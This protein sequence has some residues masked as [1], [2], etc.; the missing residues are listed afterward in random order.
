RR[1]FTDV[2]IEVA[3]TVAGQASLAVE[4]ARL[5]DETLGLTI[6]NQAVVESIQQGI[7]VLD[8]DLTIRRVNRYMM[9]RY[10]WSTSAVGHLLFDHRPDYAAFLREPI[11]VVLALGE[12]QVRYEVERRD[13]SGAPSI[14]NYYLYPMREGSAVT[15]IVLLLEDVTERARLEADLN[16][17][18]VQMAALSEVSSRITSTLEPD[19]VIDVVLDALNRVVPYDGVSLWLRSTAR[20][21]LYIAAARG[22]ETPDATAVSE[23]VGLTVE[24]AYSPLFREMADKARV[25]NARDV[26]E[27]PR[28]PYGSEAIY[29]NWLGAP[30]ISKGEIMGVMALEKREPNYYGALHE[31]LALTFAN[32]AAVALDNARLFQETR[33]RASALDQQAQRLALLNRVSLALA[34]TLDLENIFEIALRE[35]AIALEAVEGSAMQVD[36]ENRLCTVIVEYPRGD[37]PPDASYNLGRYEALERVVENLI[38]LVVDYTEDNPVAASMH[39][40]LRRRDVRQSLLVPMVVGGDVIGLLRLDSTGPG[41]SFT[42]DQVELAQTITSQAATAVQNAGLF[43][44]GQIRT[45]ELETLFESAQATAVTLDLNEVMRR[46]TIQMLAAVGADACAVFLWDDVN[47]LLDVRGEISAR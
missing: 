11:A 10:N 14:R 42:P 16:T 26:A 15:G 3:E 9:E 31:Q 1:A 28:F 22:Y 21:E 17:R 41:R 18:A 34:Q 44:Q 5:Y 20:E 46:V 8:R 7:V 45:R 43:E 37:E 29:K 4:K 33:A 6:F 35:V 19:Q 47:D 13:E 12:P 32:Q 27:D 30:L 40:I 36:R 38:P 39:P 25:I 24:I 2:E 23:L